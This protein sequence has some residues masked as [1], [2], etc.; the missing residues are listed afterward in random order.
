MIFDERRART[1]PIA[2]L[3]GYPPRVR[4]LFFWYD[5]LSDWQR[6]KYAAV[7]ILFLLACGGYLLGLGSTM[8]TPIVVFLNVVSCSIIASLIL[9]VYGWVSTSVVAPF[10]AQ[11]RKTEFFTV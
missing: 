7:A 5:G 10:S 4:R 2:L 1:Q 9:A 11:C 8:V 3:G 6:V